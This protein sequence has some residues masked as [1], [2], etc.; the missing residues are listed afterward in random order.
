VVSAARAGGTFEEPMGLA[1]TTYHVLREHLLAAAG[2][3]RVQAGVTVAG[4][5][6]A[7]EAVSVVLADGRREGFDLVVCADGRLSTLREG[8]GAGAPRYAG[9]VLW[10]AM[11]EETLLSPEARR[12]FLDAPGL[13]VVPARPF[14]LVAYPV[15]G[16]TPEGP[17]R[18]NWGWYFGV[19]EGRLAEWLVDREGVRQPGGLR[20]HLLAPG[21]VEEVAGIAKGVWPGVYGELVA[22][23]FAVGAVSLHPVCEYLPER[24]ARGRLCLVGDA[25][26]LA[27]P[28]TGAGARTA[29]VDALALGEALGEARGSLEEALAGWEARRL[30]PARALVEASSRLGA[31]FRAAGAGSALR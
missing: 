17:R 30:G 20:A 26:H 29:M 3:A 8:F 12:W 9:Y 27:S 25:A 4:V 6:A 5:E 1:A 11:I 15:P 13:H 16:A 2:T 31:D 19:E 14:H 22:T 28:I 23:S 21:L 18:V 24:M 10:R 7:E